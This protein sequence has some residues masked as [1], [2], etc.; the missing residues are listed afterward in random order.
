[1][2]NSKEMVL[3]ALVTGMVSGMNKKLEPLGKEVDIPQGT[4]WT[5]E[6]SLSL[7]K[8]L[9]KYPE[10]KD[11]NNKNEVTLYCI[12]YELI[13]CK[14]V[15]SFVAEEKDKLLTR[16]RFGVGKEVNDLEQVWL[17]II[18]GDSDLF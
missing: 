1:M 3:S 12:A 6:D 4:N 13:P 15:P 14:K 7:S 18:A 2:P 10:P 16:N 11:K 8:F 17:N 9:D 5:A